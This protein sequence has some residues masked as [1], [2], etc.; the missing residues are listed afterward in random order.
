MTSSKKGGEL[1]GKSERCGVHQNQISW[2]CG[3]VMALSLVFTALQVFIV[4]KNPY[5]TVQRNCLK[6]IFSMYEVCEVI[7]PF[8]VFITF[9]LT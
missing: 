2:P 3:L 1:S 7:T 4:H 9:G 8:L 5:K 6:V